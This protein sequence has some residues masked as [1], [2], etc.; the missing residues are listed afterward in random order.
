MKGGAC[1]LNEEAEREIMRLL[2][3]IN[4]AFRRLSGQSEKHYL[5]DPRNQEGS[6]MATRKSYTPELGRE[7]VRLAEE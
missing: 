5:C 6:P 7:A 4:V 1:K 2:L 3:A